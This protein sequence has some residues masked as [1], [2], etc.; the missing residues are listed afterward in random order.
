MLPYLIAC[1]DG[2]A[3]SGHGKTKKAPH[4]LLLAL[5]AYAS[6]CISAEDILAGVAR[7]LKTILESLRLTMTYD[8][9]TEMVLDIRSFSIGSC[10]RSRRCEYDSCDGFSIFQV[11]VTSFSSLDCG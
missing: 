1:F 7:R 11:G 6:L 2:R 9:G 5:S 3:E 10:F 4:E 8:Q